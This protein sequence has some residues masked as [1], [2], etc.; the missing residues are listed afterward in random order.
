MVIGAVGM[1]PVGKITGITQISDQK[2]ICEIADHKSDVIPVEK[3]SLLFVNEVH[4]A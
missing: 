1:V 4:V 3:F 2:K